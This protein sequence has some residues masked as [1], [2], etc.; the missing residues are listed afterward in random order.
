MPPKYYTD[1]YTELAETSVPEL[2]KLG[3]TGVKGTKIGNPGGY[4]KLTE[5]FK[6]WVREQTA[7]DP[8]YNK[9]RD[10][11]DQSQRKRVY[12]L[13]KKAVTNKNPGYILQ[14]GE[15]NKTPTNFQE[16]DYLIIEK[17]KNDPV[18]RKQFK[19]YSRLNDNQINKIFADRDALKLKQNQQRGE[20]NKLKNPKL[21]NKMKF[22]KSAEKWILSNS[23]RYADPDKFYKAFIDKF[24]KKNHLIQAI[25]GKLTTVSNPR[26]KAYRGSVKPNFSDDFMDWVLGQS[27]SKKG[28]RASVSV[29]NLKDIFRTTIYNNNENVK[30]R[31]L[32]TFRTIVPKDRTIPTTREKLGIKE[33]L[34]NNPLLKKFNLNKAITGP[35]AKLLAKDFN[36]DTLNDIRFFRAPR[37]GTVDL[38]DFLRERVE[39]KYRS[40]FE[41]TSKALKY[42]QRSE[43]NAASKALKMANTINFDHKIPT[44]LIKRGFADTTDYIK[45]TPTSDKF[46]TLIKNPEFD[47]P[48][49]RLAREFLRKGTTNIRKKE[50]FDE[51]LNLRDTFNSKYGNY[52]KSV[53]IS[54][55]EKTN[56]IKLKNLDE[57]VTTKT[58]LT[59]P[60]QRSFLQEKGIIPKP[61][62]NALIQQVKQNGGCSLLAPRKATGGV[63][64]QTCE[65][66]ISQDPEGSAKKIAQAQGDTP[67][68]GKLKGIAQRFLSLLPKIGTPG[69]I[70]AGVAAGV[71]TIGALTYNRELGE[72][73]NPL[74]DDKASQGTLTEWI[75]ENP[76]KTVAGTSIGFSAQEI[77]GAYKKAR[78]LGRGRTRSALGITGALKPVLTTFGTP[79]MTALFEVPFGAKRLEEGETM[80]DVLTDPFGPALG[81]SLMEPLSKRAGVIRDAPTRTLGQGLRNYFNLQNVGTARPGMT[82]KFLRM[83]MS[84]RMIAGASRFLGLPGLAL[85]LGLTG[86]DAYKNYQNQEGMIYNLFNRDE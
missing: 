25:E 78:E 8:A 52:L 11:G 76:V 54:F 64:D 34:D 69:K 80:T 32:D 13:I 22:Y 57:I 61:F 60:F 74:N 43:W 62:V 40:M 36:D 71:G 17:I 53:D 50:I 19:E 45:V 68:L 15:L 12:D 18:V 51:M 37:A 3:F 67:Q 31:I 72:F 48:M 27:T 28:Q 77:P 58:D 9:R 1:K 44:A 2:R 79:A 10:L 84:P 49:S 42:A 5:E 63:A 46:N 33:L 39:P 7:K 29:E 4:Y 66:I 82:S 23:K 21:A 6:K 81:L 16:H 38:I 56:S 35:I 14:K 20:L 24:G 41:E 70:A 73:V 59:T 47:Q 83:G 55:D 26:L 65:E 30:K 85:S 86:Y 75:K